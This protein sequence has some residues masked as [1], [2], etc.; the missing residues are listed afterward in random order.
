[1]SR[2]PRDAPVPPH[3]AG[4]DGD[5]LGQ[6][7]AA[8]QLEAARNAHISPLMQSANTACAEY[9]D[10]PE[11]RMTSKN[12]TLTGFGESQDTDSAF[13]DGLKKAT[14]KASQGVSQL[15]KTIADNTATPILYETSLADGTRIR[16]PK[17]LYNLYAVIYKNL[18]DPAMVM[19]HVQESFWPNWTSMPDIMAN[20]GEQFQDGQ[21]GRN[22]FLSELQMISNQFINF[23]FNSESFM[24]AQLGQWVPGGVVSGSRTFLHVGKVSGTYVGAKQGAFLDVQPNPEFRFKDVL[25]IEVHNLVRDTKDN[26]EWKIRSTFR[27]TDWMSAFTQIKNSKATL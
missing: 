14:Q 24:E 17:A 5:A 13:I 22:G 18:N 26:G 1:M 15:S 3:G 23:T 6:M 21:P 11:M 7:L 4:F 19:Q 16:M 27:S 8:A 20:Y 2:R 12:S 25:S 10:A 9:E